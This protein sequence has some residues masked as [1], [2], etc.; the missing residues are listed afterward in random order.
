MGL[1]VSWHV[2]SSQIRDW[3]RVSCIGRQ[4][5]Y[6]WA[7]REAQVYSS[8]IK[9]IPSVATITAIHL[10]YSFHLQI[11]T[12]DPLNINFLLLASSQPLAT[13]QFILCLW[14]WLFEVP[15]ISEIIQYLS[16]C[17][18]LIS[19]SI[20][21]SKFIHVCVGI[22]SLLRHQDFLLFKA[23]IFH[24]VDRPHIACPFIHWWTPGLLLATVN[25]AARDRI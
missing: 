9:Y 25:D 6:P 11:E 22:S 3:I 8:G 7:T 20:V 2:E 24:C 12:L 17:N 1:V 13:H 21:S 19:F 4:I 10:W 5:L 15:L 16:F 23:I 18:W 14:V